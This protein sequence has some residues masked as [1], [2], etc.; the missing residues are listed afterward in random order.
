MLGTVFDNL[1]L[2]PA[3][4]A[5]VV[6][7]ADIGIAALQAPTLRDLPRQPD[8][9]AVGIEFRIVVDNKRQLDVRRCCQAGW[10]EHQHDA[11]RRAYRSAR[12]QAAQIRKLVIEKRCIK[13]EATFM[14]SIAELKCRY[15]L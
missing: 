12:R 5:A 2:R 7:L 3:G 13:L 4:A 8:L 14:H 1:E 6:G 15:V 10:V 9:G 11:A